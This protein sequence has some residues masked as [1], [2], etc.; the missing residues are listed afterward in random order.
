MK[1]KRRREGARASR[2]HHSWTI[3]LFSISTWRYACHVLTN[4]RETATQIEL[5]LNWRVFLTLTLAYFA[6]V[7]VGHL[8]YNSGSN[9]RV[10]SAL[11]LSGITLLPGRSGLL[12]HL[13]LDSWLRLP[14][15]ANFIFTGARPELS[16][17]ASWSVSRPGQLRKRHM[18][19]MN[20]KGSKNRSLI[21]TDRVTAHQQSIRSLFN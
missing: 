9:S 6:R 21:D 18:F 16:Y 1:K 17:L 15:E 4:R 7:A 11:A 10:R 20:T 5:Q 8:W 13:P 14:S 19:N 12:N 3:M 2:Y